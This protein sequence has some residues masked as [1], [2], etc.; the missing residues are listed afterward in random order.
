M[1][2][3]KGDVADPIGFPQVMFEQTAREIEA[4]LKGGFERIS[5]LAES[6]KDVES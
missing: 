6:V 2:G 3:R 5:R 4:I 1:V